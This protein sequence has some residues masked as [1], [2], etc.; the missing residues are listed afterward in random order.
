MDGFKNTKLKNT[1]FF[2]WL[3]KTVDRASLRITLAFFPAIIVT[4]VDI[5]LRHS[6]Q[7][8]GSWNGGCLSLEGTLP[9]GLVISLF[10]YILAISHSKVSSLNLLSLVG[11]P[12]LTSLLL[13]EVWSLL[14][15]NLTRMKAM[16]ASFGTIC[17]AR[18]WVECIHTMCAVGT[19]TMAGWVYQ[20]EA[21]GS[22]LTWHSWIILGWA[23]GPGP[24]LLYSKPFLPLTHG[25]SWQ[26]TYLAVPLLLV[27]P[28]LPARYFWIHSQELRE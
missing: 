27:T 26:Q 21:L 15:W 2:P 22:T 24:F 18:P 4:L 17:I 13:P 14:Q 28:G 3:R 23:F 1:P 19:W 9:G 5:E 20:K 16:R 11:A 12:Q 7:P 6:S 8:L 10:S 25:F